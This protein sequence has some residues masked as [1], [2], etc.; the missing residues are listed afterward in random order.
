MMIVSAATVSAEQGSSTNFGLTMQQNGHYGSSS[1]YN[2][3]GVIR[4]AGALGSSAS[5]S[6]YP[7]LPCEGAVAPAP[8]CG[9]GYID[10]G[11]ECDGTNFGSL[12]DCTDLG[13]TGGALQ[14]LPNCKI[15]INNCI[16]VTYARGGGAGGLPPG[17]PFRPAAPEIPEIIPEPEPEFLLPVCGNGILE[18]N[19]ECDDGNLDEGDGCNSACGIEIE[20]EE[21]V[22]AAI[23]PEPEP[24]P[25]AKPPPPEEPDFVFITND[26][27]PLLFGKFID[28]DDFE[29]AFVDEEAYRVVKIDS[30]DKYISFESE[31]SLEEGVYDVIVSDNRDPLHI[32]SIEIEVDIEEPIPLPVIE[33][34]EKHVFV[35][36]EFDDKVFVVEDRKPVIK[37]ETEKPAL[38]GVYSIEDGTVTVLETDENNEFTF[39]PP[40][41]L[42]A[43]D[44]EY[45]IVALYEGFLSKEVRLRFTIPKTCGNCVIL[46]NV[47]PDWICKI[48]I[49]L[50][51]LG[52][53]MTALYICNRRRE[54]EA[55]YKPPRSPRARK[56]L[57]GLFS[58]LL[59]LA[60][61]AAQTSFAADT[62][63]NFFVY[64]GV[65][66]DSSGNP[67]TTASTFRFSLWKSD[68]FNSG[69]D[70]SGGSINT[71]AAN[72]ASWQETQTVTPDSQGYFEIFVGTTS[73]DPWPNFNDTQHPY[74]QVEIQSAGTFQ[75]IDPDGVDNTDDRHN[76]GAEPFARN[77]DYLDNK[78][79]GTSSGDIALL[80]TGGLFSTGVIPAGTDADGWSI[81][82]DDS[83]VTIPLSFGSLAS[84]HILKWDPNGVGVGD[85][86]FQFNDD[87]DVQGNITL[88]GTVDGVDISN[89]Q[90]TDIQPRAKTIKMIPEFDSTTIQQL[91]AG[92]HKGKVEGFFEDAD[93]AGAPNNFNHYKYTTRQGTSQNMTLVMLWKVP[94]DFTSW[95]A[96]PIVFRY[97]TG[98]ANVA[99]NKI[100]ISIED[101]TGT[102]IG[103]LT[104]NSSLVSTSWTTANIGFGGGGTFTPGTVLTV[105]I[106]MTADN[107]GA[108]YVGDITFNYNGR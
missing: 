55:Q 107:N 94:N 28:T 36:Q 24:P 42:G 71:G 4:P 8:T 62:T 93:G 99:D 72:Y 12:T 84:N 104:G 46:G 91:G 7:Y 79:I 41:T 58:V 48:L 23:I 80:S 16:A 31:S 81:D 49:I 25:L 38:I 75:L 86:W 87:L 92:S 100:D 22:P 89:L 50:A 9:N 85:G 74:L 61:I 44:Y 47:L 83:A 78:E 70:L 103:S 34:L 97:K 14:C 30:V 77:S 6:V 67:V 29:V 27:I 57:V 45:R 65:L 43:G 39:I 69:T 76:I 95:Q 13:Y 53:V 1:S 26:D 51:I 59:S 68:D 11:E 88:S 17:V 90:F 60:M 96:T 21:V 35:E 33:S 108:D 5:F 40:D 106:L 82:I 32:A 63:P 54:R 52:I 73:T 64:N 18:R 101:S 102:N 15:S 3:C 20:P 98:T 37:G 66:K 56:G 10:T 19:E 2:L 105:K